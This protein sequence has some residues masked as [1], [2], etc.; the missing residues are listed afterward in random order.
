MLSDKLFQVAEFLDQIVLWILILLSII[1]VGTIIE[2]FLV[3]K[4]RAKK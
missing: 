1:S 3:L 4:N 2:R